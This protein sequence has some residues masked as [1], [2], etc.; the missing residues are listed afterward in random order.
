MRIPTL[1]SPSGLEEFREHFVQHF[2]T[3][4]QHL[5]DSDQGEVEDGDLSHALLCMAL[6]SLKG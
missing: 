1:K 2:R 5:G 4:L 6:I 3:V